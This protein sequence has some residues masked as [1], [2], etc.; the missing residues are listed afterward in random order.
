MARLFEDAPAVRKAIPV[1]L[2]IS[3]AQ[4]SGKT[5]SALRVAV[6][7]QR[8]VGG[9][10]YGCDSENGRMLHY[11]DHFKF[12]HVP[13]TAPFSPLD[14]L[15]VLEHCQ[16]RGAKTVIIDS[17][18]HSHDGPGGVLEMH[19]KLRVEL[20]AKWRTTED[21]ADR[22]AWI[23]PKAQLNRLITGIGQMPMNLIW[24]FRA[25]EKS[26]K[27][28]EDKLGFMPIVGHEL[29]FE[30]TAMALLY[31]GSDGVPT[32]DS[33]LPGER[34]MTKLPSQYREL[35]LT[36]F[37][38]KPLSEDIGQELAAW[39]A[40]GAAPASASATSQPASPEQVEEIKNELSRLKWTTKQIRDWCATYGGATWPDK[41]P[42]E[43]AIQALQALLAM[44]DPPG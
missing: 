28:P 36:K 11:A 15:A 13:F 26:G 22:S 32:W 6:G 10:V 3:G 34:L 43:K 44:P 37:K 23:E 42:G 38:G 39:A 18:S 41:I 14:Y 33:R 20:A 30:M 24:C 1:L 8:V 12:R 31:P 2:G 4:G 40:G 9:E 35:F 21:K 7:I 17:G 16:R 27:S 29:A 19:D 25:K 5:W